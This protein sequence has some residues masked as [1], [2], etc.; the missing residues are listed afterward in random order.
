[1]WSAC[2]KKYTSTAIGHSKRLQKFEVCG[3]LRTYVVEKITVTLTN[4]QN[5]LFRYTKCKITEKFFL[6][7]T[8]QTNLK[9]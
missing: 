9:N 1:M 8:F 6:N 4:R 2:V 7:F 5:E 3:S